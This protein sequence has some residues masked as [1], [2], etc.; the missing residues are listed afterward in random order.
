MTLHSGCAVRRRA[1]GR[2]AVGADPHRTSGTL[3]EQ[4]RLVADPLGVVSRRDG[5]GR[6]ARPAV[7]PAENP[8]PQPSR[9]QRCGEREDQRRLP[10]AAH[11]QVADDD[12]RDSGS[13][14]EGEHAEAKQQPRAA[15]PRSAK[16]RLKGTAGPRPGSAGTSGARR[17]REAVGRTA[18]IGR[19]RRATSSS[20]PPRTP[21]GRCPPGAPR[22]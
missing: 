6:G 18:S 22:P 9:A 17:T 20:A 7:A 4:Q 3:G 12:H 19:A 21:L 8:G 10:G 11:G 5:A 14:A 2:D 15:R 13:R 16:T 1:R